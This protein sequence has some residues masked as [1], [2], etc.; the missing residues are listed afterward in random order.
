M[1]YFSCFLKLS[2][3]ESND[4]ATPRHF[5]KRSLKKFHLEQVEFDDVVSEVYL[6][7]RKLIASGGDIKNLG[8]GDEVIPT[9]AGCYKR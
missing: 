8:V 3:I 1:I 6:R 4:P 9:T 2:N 7:G 5:I